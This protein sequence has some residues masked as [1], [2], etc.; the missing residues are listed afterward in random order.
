M[1]M[2]DQAPKATKRYAQNYM[3]LHNHYVE[4]VKIIMASYNVEHDHP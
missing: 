4:K 3:V 2:S 1:L